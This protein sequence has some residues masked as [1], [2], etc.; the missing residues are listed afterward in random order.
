MTP[1]TAQPQATYDIKRPPCADNYMSNF[2]S[3]YFDD[4]VFEPDL[5]KH[6]PYH[7]RARENVERAYD[8]QRRGRPLFISSACLIRSSHPPN[9]PWTVRWNYQSRDQFEPELTRL[10]TQRWYDAREPANYWTPRQDLP[11]SSGIYERPESVDV[12]AVVDGDAEENVDADIVAVVAHDREERGRSGSGQSG[13]SAAEDDVSDISASEHDLAHESHRPNRRTTQRRTSE[14]PLP[15]QLHSRDAPPASRRH[16]LPAR[17]PEER[18]ERNTN[19]RRRHQRPPTPAEADHS[20]PDTTHSVAAAYSIDGILKAKR[21]SARAQLIALE[22]LSDTAEDAAGD[23]LRSAVTTEPKKDTRKPERSKK[24]QKE[25]PE[26]KAAPPS[27]QAGLPTPEDSGEDGGPPIVQVVEDT[28][29]IA[30]NE[31]EE[32]G[33]ERHQHNRSDSEPQEHGRALTGTS[34]KLADNLSSITEKAKTNTGL[35]VAGPEQYATLGFTAVNSSTR[36]IAEAVPRRVPAVESLQQNVVESTRNQNPRPVKS[37]KS[38]S[39]KTTSTKTGKSCQEC[40]TTESDSWRKG[41][42]GPGTLCGKCGKKYYN[43]LRREARAAAKA[44][45]KVVLELA[46][47]SS[48]NGGAVLSPRKPNPRINKNIAKSISRPQFGSKTAAK[49]AAGKAKEAVP[50]ST[51]KSLSFGQSTHE[52]VLRKVFRNALGDASRLNGKLDELVGEVE[53]Q[54]L[55]DNRLGSLGAMHVETP[56][57]ARADNTTDLKSLAKNK[58]KRMMTFDTPPVPQKTKRVRTEKPIPDATSE[59]AQETERHGHWVA[60]MSV[61]VLRPDKDVEMKDAAEV[62]EVV[63]PAQVPVV[64][65]IPESAG[66]ATPVVPL[67]GGTPQIQDREGL[68]RVS[69]G[70]LSS[71]KRQRA[72]PKFLSSSAPVQQSSQDKSSIVNTP[73]EAMVQSTQ[74]LLMGAVHAFQDE[75]DSSFPPPADTTITPSISATKN[76]TS[77][78]KA[79]ATPYTRNGIATTP[80]TAH[81]ASSPQSFL[82]EDEAGEGPP[83]DTQAIL[84]DF[85]WQ[86][87]DSPSQSY[88]SSAISK[89]ASGKYPT[90]RSSPL[91]VHDPYNDTDV[92]ASSAMSTT[93]RKVALKPIAKIK[94]TS[95]STPL[96]Q[97]L[98]NFSR[99]ADQPSQR[100]GSQESQGVFDI[101][102]FLDNTGI[103]DTSVHMSQQ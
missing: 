93:R 69:T 97:G 77:S 18:N 42:G 5:R 39:T 31:I 88:V 26:A 75:C 63:P 21:M 85:E 96:S 51:R 40:Q 13:A 99:I 8:A 41:P 60:D 103:L 29:S 33:Q 2:Q 67:L 47:N 52:D 38:S 102:A 61:Q 57:R 71:R 20:T 24:A 46:A 78:R 44:R 53:Y 7:E 49:S 86:H 100:A 56:L 95:M 90:F 4:Y 58:N 22:T 9:Q 81:S 87:S 19:S 30:Q 28:F 48:F 65:P 45:P 6:S 10:R 15:Y 12:E 16:E 55:L 72:T 11:Q 98:F 34:N 66:F 3:T 94:R 101:E 50:S 37:A 36:S 84:N 43:Q 73:K 27:V 23:V 62:M 32:V 14:Q 83:G 79:A 76:T 59:Q 54:K 1:G 92:P 91:G 70:K 74:A 89:A 25:V 68:S 17:M 35:N 64:Q 82:A 80:M